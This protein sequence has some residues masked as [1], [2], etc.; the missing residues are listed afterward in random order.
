MFRVKDK[1]TGFEYL[2]CITEEQAIQFACDME[3]M[4]E[5]GALIVVP[6]EG[7]DVIEAFINEYID[8]LGHYGFIDPADPE[9]SGGIETTERLLGFFKL[10]RGK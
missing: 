5:E 3:A 8:Q 1:L 4:H 7:D 2:P 10:L 6:I 9:M